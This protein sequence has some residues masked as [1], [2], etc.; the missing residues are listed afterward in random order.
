MPHRRGPL[1]RGGRPPAR[2]LVACAVAWGLSGVL[3]PA[4]GG[5]D[6]VDRLVRSA[7]ALFEAH[8][9]EGKV[10]PAIEEYQKAIVLDDRRQ[11]AYWKLARAVYVLGEDLQDGAA[12]AAIYREGIEYAKMAVE[13]DPRSAEAHFWLGLLY[14]VFGRAQGMMQSLHLIE[15]IKN[16]MNRV[17]ELDPACENAGAY[18][19]LGRMYWALPRWLGG[20]TRRSVEYL[21]KAV[22]LA[23]DEVDNHMLLADSCVSEG[24]KEE[25]QAHVDWVA[26]KAQDAAWAADHKGDLREARRLRT[27]LEGNGRHD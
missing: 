11:E 19:V 16:E 7:D 12:A 27:R 20:D 26:R 3:L 8:R 23:P 2:L 9:K 25:A 15:P 17:L 22:E 1:G 14:G 4:A 6:A 10:Q 18:R 5:E 21:R 13:L 24:L